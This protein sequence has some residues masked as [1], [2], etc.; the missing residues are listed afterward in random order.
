MATR[1]L[2]P[3]IDQ[4]RRS[5][6]LRDGAG[7]TDGQLLQA[8]VQ[9]KDEAA[10]ALL[11]RRHGPMVLG[12]CRRVLRDHHDAEDAFQAV[13]L[14]LVRKADAI[15]P[16]ERVANWLYGVAHRTA[17]KVRTLTARRKTRERQVTALPEPE[18]AAVDNGWRD[19]Q[20]LLDQELSRLP[21][22]YR[23]PIVLCDLEGKTGKEAARQLGW[24]EGTIASRLS[25]GRALLAKRL[26][27]HGL[28]LSA[29]SLAAVL[30]Q[31]AAAA[32]VPTSLASPTIKAASALAAGQAL[33]AG[34]VSSR[35]ATLT[36]GVLK[37]MLLTK[38]KIAVA[39]VLM[40]AIAGVGAGRWFLQTEAA[41]RPP[42]PPVAD[43]KDK[44][45]A[46]A[47]EKE[48]PQK[49]EEAIQGTWVLVK[50][51]QVNVKPQD[52]DGTFKVVI[53]GDKIIYPDKSEAKF[54]LDPTKE[55]KRFEFIVE[56]GGTA[57]V[58]PGIYSLK[59]DEL[60]YCHGRQGDTEPPASFD[61]KKAK[62]GTFPS[63]WTYRREK[64]EAQADPAK[65]KE[66][67]RQPK[68]LGTLKGHTNRVDSLAFSG[69]RKTLASGSADGT[70]KL[71][72]AATGKE[73]A[74]FKAGTP[75]GCV[76][77]SPDG[78]TL[79][80][81][82]QDSTVQLWDVA[83]G[84]KT[85]TIQAAVDNVPIII[86]CVA[87]SPDGKA[88]ASGGEGW[89]IKL[90]DAATARQTATLE[91]HTNVVLSV[92]FSPDSKTLA[93]ASGDGTIKLWDVATGTNSRT[94]QGPAK[95]APKAIAP[96][97]PGDGYVYGVAFSPDGKT[98]ASAGQDGAVRL[99]DVSTGKNTAT[100]T[101]HLLVLGVAF[102]PDGKTLASG[103]DDRTVKLWDVAT[104]KE[105]ATLQGHTD[106]VRA[107]AFGPGGDTLASGS[108][109]KTIK[110]WRVK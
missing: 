58:V 9:H 85:A 81:A 66:V 19:W 64:K 97:G 86:D 46:D 69:D 76:A 47:P 20:P 48:R 16:R 13:F 57:T 2:N 5:V 39:V 11:V 96:P 101:G 33:T 78:K 103:S 99:W 102:S 65:G 53:T 84:K 56:K 88:L 31:N 70:I 12:V 72:D 35:V 50:L 21:D 27:R 18:A 92:A 45:G 38:L 41:E 109:D 6:L 32:G 22:K 52:F 75:V 108:Y 63:C 40:L 29:G 4:L 80:A 62:P 1:G 23:V 51:D 60:K 28:A 91:G 104:G 54:R 14:V 98:L 67:F 8:F 100:F 83:A 42:A 34:L 37:T 90:W 82:G 7:L 59:G 89:K 43:K 77:F 105:I 107:V 3:V 95:A 87:F 73:T 15:V 106:A 94:L 61:I 93:S 30:S 26:T 55:P 110:L 25:R 10:F 49:D 68:E 71:W 24:P 44:Q 79:A 36:E 74:T 17:L